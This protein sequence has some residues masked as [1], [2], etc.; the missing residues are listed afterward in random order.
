MK[1]VGMENYKVS[2]KDFIIVTLKDVSGLFHS[3]SYEIV[4]TI[5][6]S[7][8]STQEE[9]IKSSK[10]KIKFVIAAKKLKSGI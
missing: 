5:P 3:N 9:A 6:F 8:F 7:N 2:G 1:I 4:N 10:E